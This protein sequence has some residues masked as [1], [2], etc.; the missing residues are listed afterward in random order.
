MDAGGHTRRWEIVFGLMADLPDAVIQVCCDFSLRA[1]GGSE[2][3]PS[4]ER[5]NQC[6]YRG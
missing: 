6:R 2:M 5:S 4:T 3:S 1:F